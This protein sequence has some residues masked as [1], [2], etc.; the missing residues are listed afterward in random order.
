MASGPPRC[1]RGSR[2]AAMP[3]PAAPPATNTAASSTAAHAFDR[4]NIMTAFLVESL[5]TAVHEGGKHHAGVGRPCCRDECDTGRACACG[6]ERVL[7]D[8]RGFAA[9][10]DEKPGDGGGGHRGREPAP[11]PRRQHVHG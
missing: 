1:P 8:R 10:T 5:T 6:G 11:R 7:G 3:H 9:T 4:L 2:Q